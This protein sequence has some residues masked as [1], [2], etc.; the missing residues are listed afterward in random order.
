MCIYCRCSSVTSFLLDFVI[1][2]LHQRVP[3]RI[4][5][6]SVEIDCVEIQYRNYVFWTGSVSLRYEIP[7]GRLQTGRDEKEATERTN[8]PLV[9]AVRFVIY[10][11][12]HLSI[13]LLLTKYGA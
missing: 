11:N 3:I 9:H 10:I 1:C 5:E 4:S 8:V 7:F 2:V 13:S 12:K 6:N